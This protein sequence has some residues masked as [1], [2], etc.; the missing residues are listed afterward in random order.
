MRILVVCQH[1][2]PEPFNV[3]EVCEELVRR[4]HEIT[5]MTGL[6]NYP[7]GA[8]DEEYRHGQNRNE[9]VGGVNVVRVPIVARGK[10]LVGINK[11][12]RV[13]NYIS[14]PFMAWLTRACAK[15]QYDFVL[16]FQYSPI[17]MVL[18]AL[19]IA[20]KQ[21]IPVLIWAF[22]LWPEDLLSGGFE[23]SSL[24]FRFMKSVS[25][26]IYERADCIAVTSRGFVDY[27]ADYLHLENLNVVWL[28]QFAEEIF[29]EMPF[30]SKLNPSTTIL[31]FAGNVGGNQSVETIVRAAA[32]LPD[33]VDLEVH[34]VGS[35]SHLQE[36]KRLVGEL[37]AK[38][39]C[40]DGRLPLNKMPS[41]YQE[42]SAMLL[43][44]AKPCGDSLVP[45]YT[46][47]RK[48][49]SYLA[50]KKPVI[51]SV[52]GAAAEIIANAESGIVC[53]AEDPAA[54]AA[55]MVQFAELP[56]EEKCQMA[57]N[58]WAAYQGNYSRACFYERLE[59]IIS[60]LTERGVE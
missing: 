13:L 29:E 19:R 32:L 35:G 22:D 15:K 49:Q 59:R 45:V 42:S 33:Q 4:G 9:M 16:A 43:T 41:V 5:V 47:P 36:C 58:A 27:F 38:K 2:K 25:A 28:P 3:H 46:V 20:R 1:Y 53:G 6:P 30:T 48:V 44:L 39:V 51:C 60:S 56:E 8:V 14:F 12:K 52:D 34:I 18:P 17:L 55:A 7:G 24:V 21:K 57:S 37:D 50:A 31:T 11:A 23:R 10:D 26:K 54:L 40:F